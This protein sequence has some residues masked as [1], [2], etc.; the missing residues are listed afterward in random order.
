MVRLCG[1]KAYS[2]DLRERVVG[3]LAEGQSV[4]SVALRFGVCERTVRRY[5]TLAQS[6]ELAPRP[7]PGAA[8]RL[9]PEQEG[10][11]VSLV[12]SKSDWT[13]ARLS[14]EWHGRTGVLLPLSTLHDHLKRLGGRYKK[15]VV[16]PPSATKPS[17]SSSGSR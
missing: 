12:Q 16:S 17:V 14:A 13:L 15:R 7:L 3:A 8:P 1:V 11:F 6:G 10:D 2:L 5:R 9:R 4:V